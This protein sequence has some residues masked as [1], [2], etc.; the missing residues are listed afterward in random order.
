[1]KMRS[2]TNHHHLTI[3]FLNTI[4]RSKVNFE[5]QLKAL[6]DGKQFKKTLQLFD[7]LEQKDSSIISN[8][9]I[10]QALKACSQLR[11][12]QRGSIIHH[13]LSS[14]MLDDCHILSS[15]IH[16]YSE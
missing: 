7:E 6:N 15:L 13:Q 3:R 1:M 2:N 5:V 8:R 12:R 4:V 16:L 11:D 9:V 14:S 10:T